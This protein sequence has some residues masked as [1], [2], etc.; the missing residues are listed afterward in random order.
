MSAIGKIFVGSFVG[1]FA[2]WV[3]GAVLLEGKLFLDGMETLG[4]SRLGLFYFLGAFFASIGLLVASSAARS[5]KRLL[6]LFPLAMIVVATFGGMHAI[7]VAVGVSQDQAAI[8]YQSLKGMATL[9]A[10]GAFWLLPL[11]VVIVYSVMI[12]E[13]RQASAE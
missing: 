2:G 1:I 8:M 12:F 3:L 11:I 5:W 13:S 10:Y 9:V 4:I 6:A 7:E